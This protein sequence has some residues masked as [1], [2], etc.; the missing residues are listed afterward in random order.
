MT[1]ASARS[2]VTIIAWKPVR[3]NTL[4]GFA[5]VKIERINLRVDDVAVHQKGGSRWVSLP[6]KPM[7]DSAG[8]VMRDETTGKARYQSVLQWGDR[9]TSDRFS[10]AVVEA[11]LARFPAAFAGDPP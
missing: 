5:C 6:A 8:S 9:K 10:A 11:V 1:N 2:G 4:F 7:L 3:R